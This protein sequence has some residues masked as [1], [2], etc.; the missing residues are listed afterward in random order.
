MLGDE[1]VGTVDHVISEVTGGAADPLLDVD[2]S[3]LKGFFFCYLL[4]GM[5]GETCLLLVVLRGLFE[6]IVDVG[7]GMIAL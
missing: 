7:L 6:R 5:A 2:R 1:L 3:E 4:G